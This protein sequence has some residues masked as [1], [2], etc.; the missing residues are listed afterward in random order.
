MDVSMV[1]GIGDGIPFGFHYTGV[2]SSACLREWA[3]GQDVRVDDGSSLRETRIWTDGR[4]GLSVLC[5]TTRFRDFPAI[6]WMVRFRNDGQAPTPIIRDVKDMDL[7]L[8]RAMADGPCTLH[9]LRGAP[10]DPTDNEPSTLVLR[11]GCTETLGGQGGRSSNKDF[12]FFRLDTGDGTLVVAVGWSG[13]WQATLQC[14]S[15]PTALRMTAGLERTHFRLNPGESVRGCRMLLLHHRGDAEQ[16]HAIFRRLIWKHYASRAHGAGSIS[17]QPIAGGPHKGSVEAQPILFCNTCFTRGGLWLNECN[18]Q[19]QISLIRALAPLGVQAVVTDAGWF[20]GGWPSGAGNWDCDP[21]K[22]LRGMGPVAAAARERGMSYGL[23]F[24]P[25]RVVPNTALD[26]D[27]GPW[28]LRSTEMNREWGALLDF[29]LPEVQDFFFGIVEQYLKLPGLG[30]YRQDFNTDP[31]SFWRAN[32]ASDRQGIHEMKYIEGLYAYWDR[33]RATHPD[34]F[35]EECASGGRRSDL[36][37]L[38]RFQAH[39]KSD[40]WFDNLVDQASLFAL[41]AYL[42]NATISVPLSRLDDYSFHS[43]MASSLIPGWIADDPGFDAARAGH[44][45]G[46]Y[47]AVRHLLNGDWYGLTAWSRDLDHWLVSQYHREDLAE[48]MILAFRRDHCDPRQTVRLRGLDPAANYELRSTVTE[49]PWQNSG[50]QL[51]RGTELLL[52]QAPSSDLI[53]YRRL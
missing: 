11:P 13:Q 10:S 39:Q 51:M 19:N 34:V 38:M 53:V 21:E 33:I 1:D 42:P 16:S 18:E 30:V 23:W 25:E 35:M 20:K 41:S 2:P 46:I 9:K 27:H 37:T 36:E 47:H 32:D 48:G 26:R 45:T 5:T 17:R 44:L 49:H 29:G 50:A 4:T 14:D 28:V 6:E 22:Y 31:L 12:P 40:Y 3:R 8:P 24:E 52:Q 7:V 43:A 15:T